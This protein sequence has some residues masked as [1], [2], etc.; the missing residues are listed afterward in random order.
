M[1]IVNILVS[2]SHVNSSL[3]NRFGLLQIHG[4]ALLAKAV[5]CFESNL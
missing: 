4:P 5:L 2:I 3:D 1:Y